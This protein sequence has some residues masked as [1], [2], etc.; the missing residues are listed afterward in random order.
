MRP[1]R[2][3]VIYFAIVLLGGALLAP[4]LYHT[5]QS[6]AAHSATAAKLADEPFHRYL[7]RAMLIVAL[8]GLRPLLRRVGMNTWRDLGLVRPTGHWRKIGGGFALGFTSLAIAAG[9]ALL[10]HGRMWE[11]SLTLARTCTKLLGVA[12]T[13]VVVSMME[14]ILFRGGIFGELRR[15]LRWPFAL[16]LSSALYAIVHFFASAP[17]VADVTWH[18]GLEQLPVMLRGFVDWRAL[19]PG[20]LNLL[21]AGTLLGLAYQ[22]TGNLWCSIGLHAGWIF[23][24]KSYGYL[25]NA[26]PGANV[27]FWG[28][29]SLINGWL[30]SAVLALTL[31]IFL[32]L[33]LAAARTR[34]EAFSVRLQ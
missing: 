10:C 34:H 28:S 3:L 32:R 22:R 24:L 30:A 27:W 1:L 9:L 31:I 20:F 21:L 19:I 29:S 12:G 16:A 17:P 7:N 11:E 13:A 2:V 14:E 6:L 23:W 8:V 26:V 18:T 15:A 4:W 33:P 5:M 25:T